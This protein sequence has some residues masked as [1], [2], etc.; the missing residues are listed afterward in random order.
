MFTDDL[1]M[2]RAAAKIVPKLLN[3]AQKDCRMDI[4]QEMLMTFNEDR[5]LLE[6]II[7][8]NEAWVYGYVYD[9]ETKAQSMEASRRSK[10][11]M[12][13]RM[14]NFCHKVVWSIRNTILNLCTDCAK[15]FVVSAQKNRS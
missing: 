4:A 6:K 13:W 3:F 12:P 11:A 14:M 15:Q 9:I 2:K 1:G 7:T 10:I 8:H 5:D